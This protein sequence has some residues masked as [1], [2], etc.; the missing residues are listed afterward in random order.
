MALLSDAT[1]VIEAS[2][3]SGTL[4]QAA[5]CVRLGR[6]LF[7]ARNVVENPNL[8]WP[9]RFLSSERCKI[10]DTTLQL[11]DVVF[12]QAAEQNGT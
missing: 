11:M 6:W 7:V 3:S 9:S 8:T 12:G 2:D 4:H 1:V 5:E 10:L